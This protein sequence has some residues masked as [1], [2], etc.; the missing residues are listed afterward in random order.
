MTE[1]TQTTEQTTTDP[2]SEETKPGK[3]FEKLFMDA[4]K[5]EDSL[6]AKLAEIES[7]Q[8][9]AAKAAKLAELEK[10][11]NIEAIKAQ[12][13]ADLAAKEAEYA[14]TLKTLALKDEFRKNSCND[15]YF[16]GH[17]LGAY[18]GEPEGIA[19]YV[20]TLVEDEATSKYFGEPRAAATGLDP[21]PDVNPALRSKQQT[22]EARL[23]SDDP[24]VKMDALAE[25]LAGQ[26]SGK[27]PV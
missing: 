8:E 6:K 20:K 25:R 21:A 5:R 1:E 24:K 7:K 23:K 27:L 12:Y 16:I 22:L 2:Q 10:S 18:D 14:K 3:N 19:E 26:L 15:E 13:A 9:A 17:H 4:R 11:Q